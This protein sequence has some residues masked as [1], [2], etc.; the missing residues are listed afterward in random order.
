[1]RKKFLFNTFFM[2]VT[3]FSEVWN[4]DI[5]LCKNIWT[6]NYFG[7]MD[8]SNLNFFERKHWMKIC[9]D[10]IWF[11]VADSRRRR[12]S[13]DFGQLQYWCQKSTY[14]LL[15]LIFN[16]YLKLFWIWFLNYWLITDY[17]LLIYMNETQY[18]KKKSFIIFLSLSVLNKLKYKEFRT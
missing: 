18:R 6:S 13:P 14:P 4:F 12:N 17:W 5:I 1:M 9:L 15:I 8:D 3:N 10:W 2:K 7:N 11:Y 16:D